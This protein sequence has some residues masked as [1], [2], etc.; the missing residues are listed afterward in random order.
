MFQKVLFVIQRET[1]GYL[2]LK[3]VSILSQVMFPQE[4]VQCLIQVKSPF[5]LLFLESS[6]KIRFQS[7]STRKRQFLNHGQK[8]HI[9]LPK[10]RK[11]PLWSKYNRN[12]EV[13]SDK[14]YY[15]ISSDLWVI[16][17][18]CAPVYYFLSETIFIKY[19]Y[20]HQIVSFL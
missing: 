8:I 6:K 4:W 18:G 12:Y 15:M 1:L 11:L 20:V 13:S 14:S 2:C 9:T 19:F 16:L 10:N 3:K 5:S 7:D 17:R